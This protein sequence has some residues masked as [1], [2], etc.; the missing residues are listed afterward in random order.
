M[1]AALSVLILTRLYDP[2]D[3]GMLSMVSSIAMVAG[4]L[5]TLRYAAA[6]PLPRTQL[7]ARGLI[8]L[9]FLLAAGCSLLFGIALF[10]LFRTAVFS[11][12]EL[13][14]PV[15]VLLVPLS[16]F[17]YAVQDI[18][19]SVLVRERA[20][21]VSAVASILHSLIGETFKI[22]FGL[23]GANG[24]G[25][26]AGN[27]VGYVLATTFVV[28][29]RW[30]LVVGLF[31]GLTIRN[32]RRVIRCYLQF[33]LYRVPSHALMSVSA[34]FPI[35]FTALRY[36]LALTGQL[37]LAISL[38]ALPVQL[39][40]RT[41]S[42]VHYGEIATFGRK[43]PEEVHRLTIRLIGIMAL[44]GIFPAAGL[45]AFGP[46]IFTIAFGRK[47]QLA[48]EFCS[49]LAPA[50]FFQVLQI[51]SSNIFDLYSAQRTAFLLNIQR[52]ILVIGTILLADFGGLAA[53]MVIQAYSVAVSLHYLI[54]LMVAY[55]Y[56]RG[57]RDKGP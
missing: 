42:S 17:L 18:Y 54:S 45:L 51:T 6:I 37:G 3:F 2:S 33:P 47:W 50:V 39:L 52:S 8:A 16:V 40:G 32:L 26:V 57:R 23:F 1:I 41:I 48:G 36:D 9:S 5:V 31:D 12:A 46:A 27:Q 44:I 28:R 13:S 7:S 34:Q 35:F 14:S 38:I 43:R 22:A 53:V 49:V 10:I 4:P 30:T 56:S 20:F 21:S 19:G 29:Q 55:R 24:I 25:L 11:V 15:V